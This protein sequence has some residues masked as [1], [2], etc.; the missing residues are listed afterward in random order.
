MNINNSLSS[1]LG[2]GLDKVDNSSTVANGKTN[3]PAVSNDLATFGTTS[4]TK[5]NQLQA[6]QSAVADASSFNAGKVEDIKL[7]IATGS[8]MID[9]GKVADSMIADSVA[10]L[11]KA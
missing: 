10:M 9:A 3:S 2:T 4:T 11:K 5:S 8:Y 1:I 7:A 6:L